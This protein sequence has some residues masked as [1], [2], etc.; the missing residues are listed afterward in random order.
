MGRP[1]LDLYKDVCKQN[2][3]L[4]G[5]CLKEWESLAREREEWHPLVYES[6]KEND[7]VN[8]FLFQHVYI[9]M[10]LNLFLCIAED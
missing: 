1:R 9:D 3:Q 4:T 7:Y 8:R 5:I 10:L 2:L 6:V